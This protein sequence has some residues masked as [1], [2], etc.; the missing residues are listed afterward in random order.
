MRR[1]DISAGRSINLAL[2]ARGLKALE[3]VGLAESIKSLA[4]PMEGRMIHSMDSEL[5]FQPY[6]KAGQAI[7]SVSRQALNEVLMDIAESDERVKFFFDHKCVDITLESGDVSV[8][9]T[10]SGDVRTVESQLLIGADGAFS[11]VRRRLQSTAGFDYEQDFLDHSYKELTIP[12][13]A[14]GDFAMDS[15]A[16]HI[17]P[18]KDFMLIALPNLDRSFTCTL[19]LAKEGPISFDA[20]QT[21]QDVLHFFQHWFPDTLDLMP[22]LLEDF[23]ENPTGALVTIRCNPYHRADKVLIV[24]DA[25][26][27]VV[28]FYGQGMNC[29]FE[30]CSVLG[31]LLDEFGSDWAQVLPSFSRQ[32]KPNADALAALSMKNYIEMR[33]DVRDPLYKVRKK[34]DH[35]L[36][37]RVSPESYLPLYSMVTFSNIP[38]AQVRA[39]AAKQDRLIT[40][41]AL[42]LGAAALGGL[43]LWWW[44]KKRR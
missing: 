13:T 1:A 41:G 33:S 29:G 27:A 42:G 9:D 8:C 10:E 19:F 20:L 2:S 16:L 15:N 7:L 44:S 14:S 28:P 37:D 5:E 39:R 25:A 12:A 32:R 21:P 34:L 6:G 26:H 40:A 38:Y 30:D 22:T 35:F 18:R 24:G 31:E 43:S 23:F 4:I 36:M 17:W 3:R 11:K